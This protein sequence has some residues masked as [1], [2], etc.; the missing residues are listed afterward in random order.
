MYLK[1]ADLGNQDAIKKLSFEHSEDAL[2]YYLIAAKAGDVKAMNI[3]ACVYYYGPE[4]DDKYKNVPD[5]FEASRWCIN[6]GVGAKRNRKLALEW[7]NQAA[8]ENHP[9]AY[10][11]LG[12][13]YEKGITETISKIPANYQKALQFYQKAAELGHKK[14]KLALVKIS[15][16]NAP[17]KEIIY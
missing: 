13:I 1:A 9:N 2:D 10:Y 11:M 7:F 6:Y 5:E 14:A 15:S 3:M 8:E 12:K 16:F 4:V 17:G